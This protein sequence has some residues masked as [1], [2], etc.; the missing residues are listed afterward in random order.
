VGIGSGLFGEPIT[1]WEVAG[2]AIVLAGVTLV[3][4]GSP[5]PPPASAAPAAPPEPSAP[6]AKAD[7]GA[8]P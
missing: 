7:N 8:R 5:A 1:V 6:G 4:R 3:L 2:F